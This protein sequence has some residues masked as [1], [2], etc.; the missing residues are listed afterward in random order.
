LRSYEWLLLGLGLSTFSWSVLLLFAAWT[1]A[2]RWRESFP[3][4]ALTPSRFRLVQ[5]TL[6]VVS[7]A[8]VVSLIAAIPYGLLA[9]PDV[10]IAGA[11][12]STDELHWFNDRAGAVLPAPWVLSLSLWWYKAAMLMWALWLA[13]ALARWLPAAWR[14][15]GAGGYWRNAESAP[16]PAVDT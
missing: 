7:V 10:R 11:G 15:F 14:A 6:V 12:Q 1:F 3:V 9:N 2:I 8:A 4:Q 5:I 16:A 13:F